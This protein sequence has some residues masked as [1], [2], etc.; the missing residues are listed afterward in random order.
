[1]TTPNIRTIGSRLLENES[2]EHRADFKEDRS[3]C[4]AQDVLSNRTQYRASCC[5]KLA[6]ENE[7]QSLTIRAS[8][9][10]A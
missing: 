8:G 9:S 2:P 3:F 10:E 5:F 4:E 7:Q 1:M 6:F